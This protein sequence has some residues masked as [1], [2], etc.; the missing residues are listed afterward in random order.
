[1]RDIH[2]RLARVTSATVST[3]LFKRGFR[4]VS[5]HGIAPLSPDQPTI[6]GPVWT[7]RFTPYREDLVD[8]DHTA[9]SRSVFRQTIEHA[10]AGSVVVAETGGDPSSGVL[11]DIL[12]TRLRHRGVA[13][14]VTDGTVR[15]V[16]GI[17]ASGFPVVCRGGAAPASVV[18]FYEAG[19]SEIINCGGVTILPGD[20]IIADCDGAVVIPASI[21][22]PVVQACEEQEAYEAWAL[23]QVKSGRSVLEVYP[24][25]DESREEFRS[26][27]L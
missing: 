14:L 23:A 6:A 25:T 26:S 13:G 27:R 5:I 3:Q 8:L 16:N 20:S 17:L 4:S 24:G 10:P 2:E 9:S 21:L 11:G 15:D 7:M 22:E 1:M 18:N 19:H 12:S